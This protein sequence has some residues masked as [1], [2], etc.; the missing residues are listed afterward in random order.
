M[1]VPFPDLPIFLSNVFVFATNLH[2]ISHHRRLCI[3]PAS[4][5]LG[6]FVPPLNLTSS[7]GSLCLEL[8]FLY[9]FNLPVLPPDL[10]VCIS[11]F[12]VSDTNLL[13]FPDLHL[14]PSDLAL[15][16]P[17]SFGSL[18]MSHES[19]YIS[20]LE[21]PCSFSRSSSISR[22]PPCISVP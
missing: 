11:N 9:H 7:L 18:S 12:H 6:L 20:H 5:I 22:G 1:Y 3:S 10:R 15:S 13:I 21:S 19:P 16:T 14:H 4:P 17:A 2:W 8:N